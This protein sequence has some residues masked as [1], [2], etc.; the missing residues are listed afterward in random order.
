MTLELVLYVIFFFLSAYVL[1]GTRINELFKQGRV[2]QA[3]LSIFIISMC[4][5][6]LA[7]Q[8]VV[9]FLELTKIL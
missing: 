8:F 2:L 1:M 6:Y 9:R 5:S 4:I 7:T 3:R